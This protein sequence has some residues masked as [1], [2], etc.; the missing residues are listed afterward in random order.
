MKGWGRRGLR[1]GELRPLGSSL[2]P[3]RPW[4]SLFPSLLLPSSSAA[5]EGGRKYWKPGR[6]VE[7]P[8][9][10]L[11]PGAQEGYNRLLGSGQGLLTVLVT[12][13]FL[14]LAATLCSGYAVHIMHEAIETQRG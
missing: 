10:L 1:D 4:P 9:R 6:T 14:V 11:V 12:G 7:A 3:S 2:P 5:L 8:A 13:T